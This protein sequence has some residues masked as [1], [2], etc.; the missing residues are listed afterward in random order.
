MFS[1]YLQGF[2]LEFCAEAQEAKS[3]NRVMK[4]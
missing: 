1:P 2:T 4:S 3:V